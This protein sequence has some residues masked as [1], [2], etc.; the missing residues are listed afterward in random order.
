MSLISFVIPCFK[1]ET[2]IGMVV[3]EIRNTVEKHN[4]DL[5]EIILVNDGS[6]IPTWNVICDLC[7]KD[8]SV[9][10]L[11]MTKNFGQHN[12]LMAGIRHAKGDYIV[13]LDDDG[14]TPANEVY[15]L[16]GEL[17]KGF[18]VVYADYDNKKHSI[19]RNFGSVLNGMMLESILEKPS[20]LYVSSYFVMQRYIADELVR[21]RNPYTYLMGLVLR[22]TRN[23]SSVKVSHRSRIDGVSGYSVKKLSS[24]LI[25]GLTAFSVKPL[26]VA[27]Y[28]G[29]LNAFLGIVYAIYAVI[30][31]LT[32]PLAPMG[33]TSIIIILLIIGGM[34]LFVLGVIGEYIGRIYICLNS[35]PQYVIKELKNIQSVTNVII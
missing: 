19:F 9:K 8:V 22:T 5:Y 32:N 11:D 24:L 15:S 4:E 10:G 14:Q 31:R 23:I 28:L 18:D 1:S 34:I 2:T 17:K 7:N 27:T 25:N 12:A 3:N 20:N 13:C 6:G 29:F 16:I 21:Y 35:S 30:N 26:R 33:W